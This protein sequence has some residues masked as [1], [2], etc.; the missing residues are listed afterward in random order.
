MS[1]SD[2][3]DALGIVAQTG[4]RTAH[5]PTGGLGGDAQAL[6]DL[7][8][9]LALAVEQAEASLDR[10][11]GPGVERAEQFVEQIAVDEGHHMI[12]G[13]AIAIGH[14]VTERGVAVVADR[15]VE[16]D[17]RGEAVQLG[18]GLVEGLAV[19]GCLAQGSTEAGRTIT[20]DAD[21]AGLLVERTPDRLAD[22]EVA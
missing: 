11:T 15:L 18:V 2:G 16:R 8:E 1:G 20:G 17:R 19:A 6:A 12:L 9:A 4:N 14:Q 22:P 3:E 21:Q 5:E 13:S 10:V 7:A